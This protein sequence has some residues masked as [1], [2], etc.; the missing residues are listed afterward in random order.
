MTAHAPLEL[1]V[2]SLIVATAEGLRRLA[3]RRDANLGKRDWPLMLVLYASVWFVAR[4]GFEALV[5]RIAPGFQ[6][7]SP[8]RATF[9]GMWPGLLGAVTGCALVLVTRCSLWRNGKGHAIPDFEGRRLVRLG[10]IGNAVV[11]ISLP[12]LRRN[13]NHDH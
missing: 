2:G 11:L 6:P 12:T 10:A 3:N 4:V 5:E 1:A 9:E 8:A 13:R 7:P